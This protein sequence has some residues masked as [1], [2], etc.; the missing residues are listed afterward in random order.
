MRE[1]VAD[2]ER[3]DQVHLI[4]GWDHVSKHEDKGWNEERGQDDEELEFQE[5]AILYWNR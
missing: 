5:M 1:K 2:A 4:Y 3:K